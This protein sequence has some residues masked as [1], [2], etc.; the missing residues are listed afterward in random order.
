MSK[1]KA[2]KNMRP[3]YAVVCEGY[4]EWYYFGYIKTA[5]KYPFRLKPEMPGS[6]DYKH[7]FSKAKNILK[8]EE[9]SVVFCVFDLDKIKEDNQI[10]NFIRECRQIRSKRIVP[11]LSF[12]C[13]ELWFLYHYQNKFSSRFYESYSE[14]LPSLKKY[15]PDYR[16]EQE[17]YK[18]NTLFD[19]M[20]IEEKLNHAHSLAEKSLDYI[21]SLRS[22]FDRSFTE[23]GLFEKFLEKCKKCESKTQ[24]CNSCWKEYFSSIIASL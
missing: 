24:D 18:R 20:E 10:E 12:P 11:I 5:R 21:E 2:K 19:E 13:I 6:S 3:S 9:Y 1:R 4:T 14:L 23:I 8:E 16:K 15:V 17:Y 22:A 7:I